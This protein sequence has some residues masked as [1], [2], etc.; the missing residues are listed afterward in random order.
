MQGC[1]RGCFSVKEGAEREEAIELPLV[2]MN[3]IST[4]RLMDEPAPPLS[5]V[6]SKSV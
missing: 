3:S 5:A 6:V 2:M 1:V 4:L